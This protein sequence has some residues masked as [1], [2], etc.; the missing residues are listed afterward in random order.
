MR[1]EHTI[2]S[3]IRQILTES[4]E[5]I[6]LIDLVLRLKTNTKRSIPDILTDLRGVQGVVT[7]TQLDTS[8]K[9]E[10]RMSRVYIRIKF[11]N[12]GEI[13]KED[14]LDLVKSVEGVDML[15][16][17]PSPN[18]DDPDAEPTINFDSPKQDETPPTKR[19]LRKITQQDISSN[20]MTA[21]P[22]PVPPRPR[23]RRE[24]KMVS[25]L[26]PT[27]DEMKRV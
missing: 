8:K 3:L 5:D 1:G 14:F 24:P 21:A 25:P 23:I 10:D 4:V 7:V 13:T 2:R 17:K 18:P 27:P 26:A 12:N 15:T 22:P 16:V 6:I 19:Q 9:A 11:N 20:N